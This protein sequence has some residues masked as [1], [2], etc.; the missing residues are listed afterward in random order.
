KG[1][2][3][4]PAHYFLNNSDTISQH[5]DLVML[6]NG[7]RRFNW[8][9]VAKGNFPKIT[10]PR[11]STYL[12]ISGKIYGASPVQLRDAGTIVLL[13]NQEGEDN[14]VF[15]VPIAADGSFNDPS[16]IL[17]DTA[18]IYYQLP[19]GKG[20]DGASVQFMQNRLTAM[21]SN[22]KASGLYDPRMSDTSGYARH[23]KLSEALLDE[24]KFFE[25]KVLETVTIK[26]RG[27]SELE[28]M[29]EKY[30]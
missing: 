18:K 27:K 29:D 5:L 19:K 3:Y 16:L 25:G 9:D 11:D 8:E 13:Y 6:T 28:L 4:K 24:M 26:A 1:K 7:W 2:V 12:Y 15:S 23:F 10:Y 14:Q 30:A 22:E 21:A 17:F 20:L